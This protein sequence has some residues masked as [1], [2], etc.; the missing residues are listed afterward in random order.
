MPFQLAPVFDV[1][2]P[3][4][5]PAFAED[6][7]VITDP[8]TVAALVE[9]L[10]A[11]SMVLAT[12]T[13]M[14]DVVD[15]TRGAAVPMGFMTDGEWIWTETV[16][17]YLREYGISPAEALL[18]HLIVTEDGAPRTATPEELEAAVAFLIEPRPE[19][20]ADAVWSVG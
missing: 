13:L 19:Q 3:E 18:E 11:G 5:G 9:R 10:E 6:H 12:P 1:V 16:I 7:P 17:Y 15:P 14:D 20:Q 4:T 8:E 2:D